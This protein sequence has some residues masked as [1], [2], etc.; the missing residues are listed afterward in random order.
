MKL[1]RRKAR[2]PSSNAFEQPQHDVESLAVRGMEKTGA[3]QARLVENGFLFTERTEAPLAV[4]R[5]GA[6]RADSAERLRFLR[7]IPQTVIDRY[8]ISNSIVN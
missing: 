1:A 8:S 6:T 2:T 5:A 4:V 3:F 7:K